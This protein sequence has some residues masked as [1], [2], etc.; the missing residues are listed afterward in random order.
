MKFLRSLLVGLGL[1][2]LTSGAALAQCGTT[3]PAGRFCG[4]GTGSS[5][6]AT[7]TLIT[8]GTITPIAPGTVLGN[9]TNASAVPQATNAPVLNQNASAAPA[10]Q[11]GGLLQGVGTDA[12]P[13]RIELD[14]FGSTSFFTGIRADGTNAAPTTLIADDEIVSLNAWGYDGTSRAGPA[15]AVRIYSGGTWSGTSHPSYI[16]FATTAASSTTLTSRMRVENGGGITL[17]GATTQGPGTISGLNNQNTA[18]SSK[19]TNTSNGTSALASW[20]A[21]NGT[22]NAS[23]GIGGTGH[24]AVANIQ[25][26][27][28][29][30]S[31]SGLAGIA[32]ETLSATPIDF[33]INSVRAGGF[34]SGAAFTLNTPLAVASGGTNCAAAS[35]TCLDNITAFASTGFIQRTGAGTYSFSAAPPAGSITVGTTTV[36]S[37]TTTRVLFDNAGVLGEYTI[38][39]SGNVA[40]TTSPSFTTPSLGVASATSLASGPITITSASATALTVGLNGATNPALTVDASTVSQ[41]AGLKITGSASAGTVGIATTDSGSNSSLSINAKGTGVITIGNLSTGA[42]TITPALTLSNALTY[43][44][45]TLAN[46]VTG[47]GSMVLS[48][49]PTLTTPNLGTPSAITLTNAT[50][51]AISSCV[52]G[53]AANVATFLGTPSSANLRAALTDETGT[54]LAYFQGGDIGTPSAGV[55]TNLTSLNATQLT[56][57]TV[58]AARTSGHQNGTATNDNAAAGEIGEY[59]SS[60]QTNT[61]G[62]TNAT[63]ITVTSISL[64]AGDWDVWGVAAVTPANTTQMTQLVGS[65]SQTTNTLDTTI[66]NF[67]AIST[68]A[69]TYNGSTQAMVPLPPVRKSFASTTTVFLIVQSNFTT[70][71]NAGGGGI[72][73][74][75]A[76]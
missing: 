71:T 61:V 63:P 27:A 16:D 26:K 43:G 22:A 53:L 24:T 42:V 56:S 76:R 38:S 25:N 66:G 31:E 2:V 46:S 55:G 68:P 39:G 47:T 35:G 1:T 45:V 73:A 67:V 70:S 14:T 62:L 32:L 54:G 17:N 37:G 18:T 69:T 44:G 5:G 8:P 72:F 33:Y 40:M 49:S 74:R 21:N 28:F 11:S 15:G 3:A 30:V 57:G 10:R 58:P 29:V 65:I 50:G 7:W 51:C 13:A 12:T 60:T 59:V 19:L 41:A 36:A 48:S 75:R 20:Q 34:T 4:N 9:P 23:F 52:S 64:T 6:L